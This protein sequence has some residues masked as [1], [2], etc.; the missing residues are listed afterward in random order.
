MAAHPLPRKLDRPVSA[1]AEGKARITV[2]LDP[3]IERRIGQL[4]ARS[5][6]G[7]AFCLRELVE[8]SLDDV[9]DCCCAEAASERIRR[10]EA[11]LFSWE[12]IKKELGLDD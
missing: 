5:G 7:Q 6:R 3:E 4:V 10:G 9:E 8:R 12:E 11:Q 1:G 2:S